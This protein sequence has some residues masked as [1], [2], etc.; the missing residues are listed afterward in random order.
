MRKDIGLPVTDRVT[1]GSVLL[2]MEGPCSVSGHNQ[3]SAANSRR[4]GSTKGSFSFDP[5]HILKEFISISYNLTYEDLYVILS[6]CLPPE[7]M[8][9]VW[10]VARL[11]LIP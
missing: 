6:T 8:E 10:L 4:P 2:I 5:T 11:T 3:P 9:H 1:P 7:E